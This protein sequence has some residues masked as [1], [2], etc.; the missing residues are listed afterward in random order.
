MSAQLGLF[1][2]PP[3]PVPQPAALPAV[4]S[5]G[6]PEVCYRHPKQPGMAWTGRGKPPRWVAE[7]I[8]GGGSL[9]A[10]RVPGTQP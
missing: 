9:E 3:A 10:L 5:G 4:R 8:E 7:W 1:D 2:V 6:R